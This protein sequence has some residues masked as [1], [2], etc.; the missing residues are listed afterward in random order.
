MNDNKFNHLLCENCKK[1]TVKKGKR[2]STKNAEKED[3]N[4][5]GLLDRLYLFD[6]I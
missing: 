2:N 5:Y 1:S 3:N 6:F 4:E